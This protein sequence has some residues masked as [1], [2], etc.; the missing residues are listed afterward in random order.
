M[1]IKQD[2]VTVRFDGET[3]AQLEGLSESKNMPVAGVVR[4]ACDLYIKDQKLGCELDGVETRLAASIVKT[5]DEVDKLGRRVAKAVYQ[6]GDDVQLLIA[7]FDQIATFLFSATPEVI[8]REAAA[9][10]GNRRKAAFMADLH[11]SY[12]SRKR[13]SLIAT[14]LDELN[15]EIPPQESNDEL[16]WVE[17]E[18][19][20]P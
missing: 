6:A 14:N 4:T 1:A 2:R 3:M 12:S 17:S 8:D 15:E 7:L 16:D 9:V 20:K 18:T 10:I 19:G 11:K 5:Q 13:K